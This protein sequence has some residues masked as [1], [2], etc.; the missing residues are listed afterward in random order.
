[1]PLN[2]MKKY[3]CDILECNI[4]TTVAIGTDLR[5]STGH[6]NFHCFGKCVWLQIPTG[7]YFRALTVSIGNL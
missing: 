1:M 6:T 4:L 3:V 7:R 5:I 2:F